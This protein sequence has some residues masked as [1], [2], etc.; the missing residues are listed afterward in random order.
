MVQL[1]GG[2]KRLSPH[3]TGA[4]CEF[5]SGFSHGNTMGMFSKSPAI[6]WINGCCQ[7]LLLHAFAYTVTDDKDILE[8][9]LSSFLDR[10]TT[11]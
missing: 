11:V 5:N 10:V 7:D 3:R 2:L 8:S 4:V 9:F 6:L 1:K